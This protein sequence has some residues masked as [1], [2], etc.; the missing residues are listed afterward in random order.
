MSRPLEEYALIGD[1]RSAALI[2]RYGTIEWLCLPRFDSPACFASLLGSGRNGFWR[3]APTFGV[4]D[5]KREYRP[6]SMVL[7]TT[8]VCETGKVRVIDAM[9]PWSESPRVVRY[10]ICD[11][12]S[13]DMRMRMRIRFDYGETI[14]WVHRRGGATVAVAGPD[15]VV[16]HTDIEVHGENHSTVA[17]FTV[18]TG[19]RVGFDLAYFRSYDEAP[20]PANV[21]DQLERTDAFWRQWASGCTYEGPHREAVVRSLLTLKALSYDGIGAVIA[22]PTTSLPERLGGVRNWDYRY[23]WLR[24]ATFVLVAFLNAGYDA[25]AYA[26]RGWLLR[27]VAGAPARLQILYGIGGERRVPEYELPHLAGYADSKPV[28]VGNAASEQL[29]LDVYGEVVDVM[30]QAHRA[31]LLPSANEW[32]LTRA[33]VDA[34]AE[35]WCEPDHGLWEVRG[36][37]RHFVHSKVLAWVAIDRAIRSVE[38][39]TTLDGPV[40]E[41]RALRERIHADV[42]EHGFDA[43][44]NTFVQYYGATC[45][46]ASALLM[47]L[48]GFLPH[49]DPRVQGTLKAIEERLLVDGFVHRYEQVDA[50]VDGL[51]AGEG[52]F[53]ACSFW[54][55]DNYVLAGRDEDARDMFARLL[56]IRNDVGLLSEEYDTHE[57][58]LLGNFPQAFSHVGLVNSAFNLAKG[59]AA[60]QRADGGPIEPP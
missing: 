26:W 44:Q 23:C 40:D 19:Q 49:D 11:E 37:S 27:A 16:L 5:V 36:E 33:V 20:G 30:Y 13:V 6:D 57:R 18:A 50:G 46:D 32:A 38:E 43:A 45:L 3:L 25:E 12:G 42:C 24:D 52:A 53:I 15:A 60:Q 2:N 41:W 17:D 8:Y 21:R 31:G 14:P 34:V 58:R 7:Q 56:A 55:I 4:Q 39:T 47:P 22:A 35:R 29:Q 28:R 10:V 59:A 51:P 9:L 54:L 1:L 48:V